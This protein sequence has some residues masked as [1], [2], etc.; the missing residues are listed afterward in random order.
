MSNPSN[1]K[2]EL[3]EIH[4]KNGHILKSSEVTEMIE[5]K[6]SF[7]LRWGITLLFILFLIVV[8]A[9]WFIKY[10]ETI[11]I[12]GIVKKNLSLYQ[13]ESSGSVNS[14]YTEYIFETEMPENFLKKI[15]PGNK[16]ILKI[17]FSHDDKVA[18]FKGKIKFINRQPD[19]KVIF[20]IA[21]PEDLNMNLKK[22]MND[23]DRQTEVE[24]IA[25]DIRLL[26]RILYSL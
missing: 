15:R 8:S 22:I 7:L 18:T 17:E 12:K 16:I 26:K 10:G 25:D 14:E 11:K 20:Q 23:G 24:I 13:A 4:L 1:H 21:V 5:S 9:T 6:P 3:E 19:K 2:E